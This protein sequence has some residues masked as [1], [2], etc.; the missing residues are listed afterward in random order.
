MG[1][2][3]READVLRTWI[4]FLEDTWVLQSAHTET[5]EKEIVYVLKT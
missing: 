2:C 1:S 4:N 3:T 5:K